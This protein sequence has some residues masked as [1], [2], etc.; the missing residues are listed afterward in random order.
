M[1][2]DDEKHEKFEIEILKKDGFKIDEF[3]LFY[4]K[5]K[6]LEGSKAKDLSLPMDCQMFSDYFSFFRKNANSQYFG[7]NYKT[8]KIRDLDGK[9]WPKRVNEVEIPQYYQDVPGGGACGYYSLICSILNCR[10]SKKILSQNFFDIYGIKKC[11]EIDDPVFK[12]LDFFR[13]MAFISLNSVDTF[14]ELS[15]YQ[16]YDITFYLKTLIYLELKSQKM[17]SL[18]GYYKGG[19]NKEVVN[20]LI[21]PSRCIPMDFGIPI[22]SKLL[23]IE[24]ICLT[25]SRGGNIKLILENETKDLRGN[26]S[27]VFMYT[28]NSHFYALKFWE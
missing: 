18:L 3:L 2:K 14:E 24:I 9:D 6:A 27:V 12:Y 4:S 13:I 23:N 17:D 11:Y 5:R 20:I 10:D 8:G 1:E 21:N 19:V 7:R 28:N 16:L 26:K 15:Y 25:H 22:L